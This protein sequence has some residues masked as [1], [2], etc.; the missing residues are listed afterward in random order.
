MSWQTNWGE[1]KP[2][3]TKNWRFLSWNNDW[4][5]GACKDQ[6]FKWETSLVLKRE[7]ARTPQ[8]Q[9]LAANS[10]KSGDAHRKGS[11]KDVKIL[12]AV[13]P[14]FKCTDVNIQYKIWSLF[15]L[16][17]SCF[18]MFH[19]TSK[20]MKWTQ[21]HFYWVDVKHYKKETISITKS[22]GLQSILI[23]GQQD[24]I[25]FCDRFVYNAFVPLCSRLTLVCRTI[26][27]YTKLCNQDVRNYCLASVMS[28]TKQL[29]CI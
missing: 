5:A 15:Q 25:T 7:T 29:L 11:Q 1:T 6:A 19:W 27:S 18:L 28:S 9:E 3:N 14:Q 12:N 23:K 22:R 20:N 8:R 24:R 17:N 10:I 4:N 26:A 13:S 2:W 16:I 21:F